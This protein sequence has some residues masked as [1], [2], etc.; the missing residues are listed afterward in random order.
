MEKFIN[1]NGYI[2]R[3]LTKQIEQI[4]LQTEDVIET[5]AR[6]KTFLEDLKDE[7]S[8]NFYRSILGLCFSDAYRLLQFKA[9]HNQIS[10]EMQECLDQFQNISSLDELE[11]FLEE[12]PSYLIILWKAPLEIQLY[13]LRAQATM[14]LINQDKIAHFDLFHEFEV[15]TMFK[16]IDLQTI[17]EKYEKKTQNRELKPFMP[18][19]MDIAFEQIMILSI[20]NPKQ[21]YRVLRT[22]LCEYYKLNKI[23]EVI[24]PGCLTE[25]AK[26]LIVKV[27]FC[28]IEEIV[29]ALADDEDMVEELLVAYLSMNSLYEKEYEMQVPDVIKKKIKEV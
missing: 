13:S 21:F 7:K 6:Y 11:I 16:N 12:N 9:S 2:R 20:G 22:L 28:S 25:L 17:R 10:G 5:F 27:E 18:D 19:P 15:K 3:Y 23:M 1:I 14:L 26:Q 4:Y 24:S 29:N 8:S